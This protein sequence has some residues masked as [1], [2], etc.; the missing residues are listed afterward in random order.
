MVGR[1]EPQKFK[2]TQAAEVEEQ[3]K[4]TAGSPWLFGCEA[5]PLS[6]YRCLSVMGSQAGGGSGEQMG[7]DEI[8]CTEQVCRSELGWCVKT[9]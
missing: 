6:S 3:D 5:L 8:I 2:V 9:G 7:L 4:R 1:V